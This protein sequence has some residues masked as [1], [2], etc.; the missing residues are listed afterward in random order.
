MKGPDAGNTN[1][2]YYAAYV[3]F[4]KER[5][6]TSKAKS[7]GRKKMES[8]YPRG[9]DTDRPARKGVWTSSNSSVSKNKYGQWIIDGRVVG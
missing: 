5:I 4:E 3:F 2:V 7:E 6:R 9:M 8:I 1:P